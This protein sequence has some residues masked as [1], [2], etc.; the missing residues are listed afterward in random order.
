MAVL[1]DKPFDMAD[2]RTAI[3]KSLAARSPSVLSDPGP[4]GARE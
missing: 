4:D 3:A 1:F 2:L